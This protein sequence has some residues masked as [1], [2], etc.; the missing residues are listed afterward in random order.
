M[1]RRGIPIDSE[2]SS[3]SSS[4]SLIN[5]NTTSST[6]LPISSP[7]INHS[8]INVNSNASSSSLKSKTTQSQSSTSHVHLL[9]STVDYLKQFC[10]NIYSNGFL[11]PLFSDITLIAFGKEFPA[12]RIILL[13]IPYFQ[14][15]LKPGGGYGDFQWEEFTKPSFS[16]DLKLETIHPLITLDVFLT[17]LARGYGGHMHTTTTTTTS[18]SISLSSNPLCTTSI[19]TPTNIIGHFMGGLFFG[20]IQW[21]KECIQ[22]ISETLD[23]RTIG[24]YISSMEKYDFGVYG[25]EVLNLC[26]TYFCRELSSS[27]SSNQDLAMEENINSNFDLRHILK[28]NHLHE[29]LKSSSSLSKRDLLKYVFSKLP[30]PWFEKVLGSNCLMVKDDYQR[31]EL[32]IELILLRASHAPLTTTTTTSITTSSIILKFENIMMNTISPDLSPLSLTHL[33]SNH[34]DRNI[35]IDTKN[36]EHSNNYLVISPQ[37]KREW[38][39]L[40]SPG[41][42]MNDHNIGITL[43]SPLAAGLEEYLKENDQNSNPDQEEIVHTPSSPVSATPS[44]STSIT[45][46]LSARRPSFVLSMAIPNINT[47]SSIPNINPC[48]KSLRKYI[49]ILTKSVIYSHIPEFQ[50]NYI[51]SNLLQCLDIS[52]FQFIKYGDCLKEKI[53]GCSK[54]DIKLGID[55]KYDDDKSPEMSIIPNMDTDKIDSQSWN[56]K[57]L[58]PMDYSGLMIP[59]FR[60][61]VVFNSDELN[62]LNRV[63]GNKVYSEKVFYAGS[64]WAIYLQKLIMEDE[65]KLGIYL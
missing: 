55:Y 5:I 14:S 31:Y 8:L 58:F 21:I 24:M 64:Y 20:D 35:R 61:S 32:I 3:S 48:H 43:P 11:S 7:F 34:D 18:S 46:P 33:N 49:S 38:M 56:N 26:F 12:H 42:D 54:E 39:D 16:L 37:T 23:Y 15:L 50:L 25:Q 53:L 63:D 62:G 1:R 30:R 22:W 51:Q 40:K 10:S 47:S 57:S 4:P 41:V 13:Q 45:T 59:P 28:G 52:C 17:I 65:T 19:L 6:P 60:F 36:I 27:F 2:S 29:N 9:P 44:N